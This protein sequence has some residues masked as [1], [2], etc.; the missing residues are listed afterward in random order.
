MKSYRVVL[1]IALSIVIVLPLVD[2][3]LVYPA[4]INL[5]VKSTEDEAV[6]VARHMSA[7]LPLQD[8]GIK[9]DSLPGDFSFKIE[10][11]RTDFNIVKVKLF[12]IDGQVLFSTDPADVGMI[13]TKEYFKN[14]VIRGQVFTKFVQQ[15]VKSLEKQKYS[16][17]VIETYVPVFRNSKVIGAFEIYYDVTSRK[18]ALDKLISRYFIILFILAFSYILTIIIIN[19]RAKAT[20]TL[21]HDMEHDKQSAVKL[22]AIM[23]VVIFATETLIMLFIHYII[24]SLP[25]ML[26]GF[27]DSFLLVVIVSPVLYVLVFRPMLAQIRHRQQAEH[28]SKETSVYLD[29]ILNSSTDMGIIATDVNLHIKYYNQEAEKLLG[30]GR[31]VVLGKTVMQM[32]VMARVSPLRFDSILKRLQNTES[33]SFEFQLKKEDGVHYIEARVSGIWDNQTVLAGYVMTIKDT[34]VHRAEQEQMRR[35]IRSVESAGESVIITDI[36]GVIEYVNPSFTKLTGYTISEAIGKN[37]KVLKSGLHSNS[38]YKELWDTI[39]SGEVWSGEITN[40]RK[41]R[42]L[43]EVQLTVAPVF[44]DQGKIEGFVAIQR[45]ITELK[46]LHKSLEQKVESGIRKI[47]QQ[48]QMLVQQSKMATM[49][50]MIGSIAHQWRQPLNALGLIIQDVEDAYEYGELD[51]NYIDN[52]IKDSITQINFMSQTIDDFRNFFKPSKEKTTFNIVKAIKEV[53]VMVK[54][55]LN[56]KSIKVETESEED[57]TVTG[58]HNEFMQVILNMINNSKDAILE[59]RINNDIHGGIISISINKHDGIVKIE[60]KDNGGGIPEHVKERIFEPYFTTKGEEHGTGIGLYMSRI[61]IEKNMGGH[62]Y[63]D[64]YVKDG[65]SGAIFTIEI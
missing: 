60:I 19:L 13:N 25:D 18:M 47:F 65:V 45:D 40:K 28:L 44:G 42:T 5:L 26:G 12:A 57:I 46:E 49:G 11:L 31:D 10:A 38:L 34:T 24:P 9:K 43:Y 3:F 14:V 36:S 41:D 2:V 7:L 53:I 39:L 17:D 22:V 50:E 32:H 52:L 63:V 55:M 27:V 1:L 30:F 51:K 29:N 35:L 21:Q 16:S 4:F 48:Q 6:R 61:I 20:E 15:G 62:L 23:I 59:N 64:N 56:S 37:P 8:K 33:H 54:A 58:Y